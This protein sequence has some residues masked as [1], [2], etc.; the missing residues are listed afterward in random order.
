MI[1]QYKSLERA[2][3]ILNEYPDLDGSVVQQSEPVNENANILN[4]IGVYPGEENFLPAYLG[5]FDSWQQTATF[6]I[7][8][9]EVNSKNGTKAERDIS[10]TIKRTINAIMSGDWSDLLD[11]FI[12]VG[13]EHGSRPEEMGSFLFRESSITFTFTTK[14]GVE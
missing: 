13:V 8:V 7:I 10:T 5:G 14:T 4:W 12:Q 11:R 6:R 3:K 2:T 1:E 9:Q